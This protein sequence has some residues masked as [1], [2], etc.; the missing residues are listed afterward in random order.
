MKKAF[1]MLELI[2]VLIVIGVLA[3]V[4]SP[5]MKSTKLREA[6]IQVVSHIRYTQHLAMVDDK[7]GDNSAGA[8][9]WYKKRWQIVF[10]ASGAAIGAN[11]KIAY[12]IFSDD[13]S[14]SREYSKPNLNE[15]ALSPL[16]S[17]KYL[18]GGYAGIL[19]T[20]DARASSKMNIGASYS[21]SKVLFTGGC[22]SARVKRLSFDHLGRP[23]RGTF[24]SYNKPYIKTATVGLIQTTCNIILRNSEG[25]V[26][27]AIEPETG[28]AYI[29]KS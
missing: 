18:S 15:L 7:Y 6:A 5:Q 9:D 14:D 16:S 19:D 3:A 2:F 10:G 23:L 13:G 4:I 26:T 24:T 27:I 20:D 22:A 21:I 11:G 12:S 25:D 29:V 8:N 28:Y 17:D 1:T